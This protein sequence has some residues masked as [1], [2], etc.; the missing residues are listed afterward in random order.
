M[1]TDK[2]SRK[3]S[4]KCANRNEDISTR[5]HCNGKEKNIMG[6]GTNKRYII[7]YENKKWSWLRPY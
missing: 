5:N 7:T 2:D 4:E 3:E 1:D 6:K